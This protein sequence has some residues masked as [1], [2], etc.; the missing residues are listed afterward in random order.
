LVYRHGSRSARI[1]ARL[2]KS[3]RERSVVCACEPV[4]EAEVRHAVQ[5]EMART[6]DDV[7]R[8]TR[9]GL[10]PCGGMRCA[11]RCGQI[12]AEG[13]GHPPGA[14]VPR[15]SGADAHR[16]AGPGASAPG[17]ARPRDAAR[18]ARHE[19]GGA[20]KR[21]LVVGAGIAGTAAALAA[22]AAGASVTLL[23]GG[24]GA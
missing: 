15:A 13:Q 24:T 21:V 1:L 17:G 10:G 8:R 14:R 5:G 18:H 2:A 22:S 19:R 6:V 9:L 23:D 3:P 11:A 16:G 4:L 20:L 12:V 7:A